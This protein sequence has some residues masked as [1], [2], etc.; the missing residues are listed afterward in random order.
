MRR[1]LRPTS[2]RPELTR[3]VLAEYHSLLPHATLEAKIR[4][5][6]VELRGQVSPGSL[7]EMIHRLAG[8]RLSERAGPE[9]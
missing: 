4:A 2:R 3:R 9:R 8:Y 1:P 6:E 7:D 5:A